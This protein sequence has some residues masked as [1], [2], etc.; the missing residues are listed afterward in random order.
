M[1]GRRVAAFG[2]RNLGGDRGVGL[3]KGGIQMRKAL[4]GG[5]VLAALTFAAPASAGCWAT[6]GLAPPP[7]GTASGE[8]WTAQI[9]VLQHGRN[10][11]PDARDATPTITIVNGDTGA[12]KTFTAKPTDPSGGRYEAQVV[13]PSAGTWRYEVFDGF[14]SWDGRPA[15][16]ARTHTFASVKIGGPGAASSS[17]SGN[18]PV[19]PVAGGLGALLAASIVLVWFARRHGSRATAPG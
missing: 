7:A 1:L 4:I 9:T 18:F 14:T 2:R 6:A 8:V 19:W 16:C 17:D 12:R 11:L 5:A 3:V 15:P 10:P 13:F